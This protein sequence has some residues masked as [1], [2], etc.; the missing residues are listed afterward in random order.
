MLFLQHHA[1]SLV[2]GSSTVQSQKKII[3]LSPHLDDA[4]LDCCDHI[5][6]WKTMGLDVRVVSIFT[7]SFPPASSNHSIR[8]RVNSE[9]IRADEDAEAMR[10]MEVPWSHLG[11][12]DKASRCTVSGSASPVEENEQNSL[13]LQVRKALRDVLREHSNR[14]LFVVPAGIG[15]H[16]DHVLVR[17]AAEQITEPSDLC[18]YIDYPYAL[19]AFNWTSRD[20]IKV[21]TTRK[22]MKAM[23]TQKRRL[24]RA[25]SS[26]IPQI[27][28]RTRLS[29]PWISWN[30]IKSY[31]EVI[32]YN[33]RARA[34]MD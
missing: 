13:D 5:L 30:L 21:I 10:L 2:D 16:V 8:S 26:Q 7:K 31:P 22:S 15:G 34:H 27:F 4:A 24:L 9:R 17:E 19:S 20:I 23:S 32:L 3:V 11:F 6:A 28:S 14:G 25:Y 29:M 12:V 18:Y 1:V 33:K